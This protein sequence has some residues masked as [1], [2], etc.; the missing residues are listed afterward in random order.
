MGRV[1]V[2]LSSYILNAFIPF[3]DNLDWHSKKELDYKDWKLIL[4]LKQKGWHLSEL[5]KEVITVLMNGARMNNN[6]LSTNTEN[7]KNS[8]LIDIKE[9]EAKIK[10]LLSNF[11]LEVHENG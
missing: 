1:S 2:Y 4:S 10:Y 8:N 6:R 11:N 5:G 9:L 7:L 3:L